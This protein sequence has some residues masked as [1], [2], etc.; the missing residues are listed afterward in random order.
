MKF[1]PEKKV[2]QCRLWTPARL[3]ELEEGHPDSRGIPP[4][5]S[6][7]CIKMPHARLDRKCF[8]FEVNL[9]GFLP[10]SRRANEPLP[11]S[12]RRIRCHLSR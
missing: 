8:Q 6:T 10:G 4:S 2:G 11:V 3:T 1:E 5:A 12:E 9:A 7:H